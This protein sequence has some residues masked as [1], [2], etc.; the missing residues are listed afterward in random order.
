MH[1][2]GHADAMCPVGLPTAEANE[3]M[4]QILW[5]LMIAHD[6]IAPGH[7]FSINETAPHYRLEL[8]VSSE[9]E[10]APYVL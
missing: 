6:S 9:Y 10:P 2:L 8:R 5:Y 7:P 1:N 4:T 3:L